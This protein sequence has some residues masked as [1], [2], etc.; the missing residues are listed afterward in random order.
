MTT[1][2]RTG[3]LEHFIRGLALTK[4]FR[5]VTY[6]AILLL[7]IVGIL[8]LRQYYIFRHC[9]QVTN[10]SSQLLFQFTSIKDHINETLITDGVINIK[11]LTA[12]LQGFDTHIDQIMHDILIPDE[13]KLSLIHQTDLV[14]LIVGMR[15]IGKT[16]TS[17]S[18]ERLISFIGK[19]HLIHS[20][21]Q[22]FNTVLNTYTQSLLLG[23]HKSLVGF[24]ALTIFVISSMLFLV[25]RFI[26]DPILGLCKKISSI[27]RGENGP[28]TDRF[29][30]T[31]TSIDELMD[32]INQTVV[33]NR[34]LTQLFD[35]IE[36][37]SILSEKMVD[38][39][40]IWQMICSVLMKSDNYCLVWIGYPNKD[41]HFPEPVA[42]ASSLSSTPVECLTT[43][44]Q[45]LKYCKKDGAFC[46]SA[47][48]TTKTRDV[49]LIRTTISQLPENFQNLF[50]V[51]GDQ[52]S[53]LSLPIV[54]KENER[55]VLTLSGLGSGVFSYQEV[56]ILS[57]LCNQ[58][59]YISG[60][61]YFQKATP[62]SAGRHMG[63]LYQLSFIG[64]LTTHFTHELVN[65]SNGVINYTQALIDTDEGASHQETK[66]LLQK[67][68]LEEKK[69]AN[70][71]TNLLHFAQ[72]TKNETGKYSV[73][74]L[75]NKVTSLIKEQ[76]KPSITEINMIIDS[77]LPE[78]INHG[79]DI[80][81][82]LLMLMQN[83]LARLKQ[84]GTSGKTSP[85]I[86][87]T[88]H[89]DADENQQLII[90]IQDWGVPH[91]HDSSATDGLHPWRDQSFLNEYLKSFGAEMISGSNPDDNSNICKLILPQSCFD[92]RSPDNRNI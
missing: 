76:Y 86:H 43:L 39:K 30:C 54:F 17:G 66:E 48:Q 52:L 38:K 82:V 36:H 26:S 20:R 78:I 64:S 47:R 34:R 81:L 8:G 22:Q 35:S 1:N 80:Q 40:E 55:G 14:G 3:K 58:F 5:I 9:E 74:T 42:A 60:R 41:P 19:L 56:T 84:Q 68:F 65:L 91:D 53:F 85:P 18:K 59:A 13:F 57:S 32:C 4:V 6:T 11:E 37:V 63:Q 7:I 75:L 46:R 2:N 27:Y 49:E 79:T 28:E 21:L 83:S 73:G 67:L 51:S 24:L 89:L 10:R 62:T 33:T 71:T 87:I 50:P 69:I 29:S 16:K 44:T 12:E 70:L 23:L 15:A 77:G 25:N 31:E 88:C 45:L 72:Q 61:N 90:T 92:D